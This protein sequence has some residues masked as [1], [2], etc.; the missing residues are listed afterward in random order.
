M[1]DFYTEVRDQVV[2]QTPMGMEG[3]GVYLSPR[4]EAWAAAADLLQIHVKHRRNLINLAKFLHEAVEDR[5]R[6]ASVYRLQID[7]LMP[8]GEFDARTG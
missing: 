2:N 8:P 7:E 3:G 5:E 1:V 4:L 6:S